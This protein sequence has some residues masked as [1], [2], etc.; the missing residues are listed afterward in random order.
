MLKGHLIDLMP[1]DVVRTNWAVTIGAKSILQIDELETGK[2]IT[3]FEVLNE[4]AWNT[5]MKDVPSVQLSTVAEINE[6][7]NANNLE[8]YEKVN[9]GLMNV[10]LSYLVESGVLTFEELAVEMTDQEE[11]AYLYSKG[12]SGISREKKYQLIPTE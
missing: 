4:D 6:V 3:F 9:E 12:C 7:I 2:T 11:L 1:S 10:N 8:I 5:K